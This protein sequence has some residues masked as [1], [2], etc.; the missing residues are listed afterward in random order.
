MH[1]GLQ[2]CTFGSSERERR[3]G[4][5]VPSVSGKEGNRK[6]GGREE[7]GCRCKCDPEVRVV[8]PVCLNR[9]G[10]ALA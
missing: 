6:V 10:L 7:L 2:V 5:S 3:R 1:D 8:E 4:V 9:V